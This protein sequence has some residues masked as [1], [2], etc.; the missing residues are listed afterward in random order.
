LALV[1]AEGA[2]KEVRDKEGKGIGAIT[3]NKDSDSFDFTTRCLNCRQIMGY[4]NEAGQKALG[5]D[6][7][8]WNV[9]NSS[10]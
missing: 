10:A 1:T 3:D 8:T 4:Y 9:S 5:V 2:P 7:N 6:N